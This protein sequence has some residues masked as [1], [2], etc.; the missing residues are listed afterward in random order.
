MPTPTKRLKKEVQYTPKGRKKLRKRKQR[1]T[2]GK[3]DT[4]ETVK[5]YRI[6]AVA[7]YRAGQG[8]TAWMK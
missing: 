4:R 2:G 5:E 6:A 1:R 3:M 7:L 8:E